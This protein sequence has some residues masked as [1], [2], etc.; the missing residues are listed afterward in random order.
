MKKTSIIALILI[1]LAIGAIASMYGD[2]STYE[3][4]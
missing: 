2:A 3:N 4:F 1:A